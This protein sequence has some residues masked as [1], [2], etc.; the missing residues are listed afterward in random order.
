MTDSRRLRLQA[1]APRLVSLRWALGRLAS[2]LTL[3]H[4]GAHPDDEQSGL[5]ALL[6]HQ[7]GMRV[8]L[9]CST[10][11]EGG[12]NALGPERGGALGVIRSREMEEAARILDVDLLWLG[13]GPEDRVRDFGFSKSGED[14]LARWGRERILERLV[15][16]YRRFRPDLVLPTFLDVP[17]QHG[18]HRAMTWAAEE[19]VRLAADPEAFP[20]QALSGLKP[21][22]VAKFHLPGWSGSG[23]AS[24][25]A[26]DDEEPPPPATLILRA[27]GP[28]PATGLAHDRLGEV[29]RSLH[30]TQGMGTWRAPRLEWPLHLRGGA[31]GDAAESDLREGLPR[32]LADLGASPALAEADEAV[33]RA[34]AAF[35]H[36]APLIA[37][38]AAAKS[39]LRRAQAEASPAEQEAHGHRLTRKLLELDA[40]LT[41]AAGLRAEIELDPP[42]PVQGAGARLSFRLE[43]GLAEEIQVS[44]EVDPHLA[45]AEPEGDEAFLIRMRPQAPILN[46]FHPHWSPLGEGEPLAL[47]LKARIGGEEVSVLQTPERRFGASPARVARLEPEALLFRLNSPGSQ[48]LTISAAEGARVEIDRTHGVTAE[49]VEGGLILTHLADQP[50][51]LM[52]LGVKIDG[53]KAWSR[54]AFSYPHIGAAE[55]VAPLVLEALALKLELPETRVGHIGGGAD[56]VGFWLERMGLAPKILG[57]E[58]LAGDLSAYDTLVVGVFAYGLRPDLQA[59]RPR[60]RR[61]MEAGG[62]LL[63]LYHRP[64]DRWEASGLP[65][66]IGTPSLRWRV[67]DPAAPVEILRPEHPFFVGPNRIRPEDWEGWDKERGLYFASRWDEAYEPLLSLSD[68]GE[69]PLRGALLTARFGKGRHTHLALTLHHQ[70]EKLNA[71]AFRLFA[72]LLQPERNRP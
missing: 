29:S 6:R 28:E 37:A 56:R 31:L 9:A 11:G 50:E 25:G 32:R 23:A 70:M 72:N 60:L 71:G 58:D 8:I 44:V 48:R 24:G 34:F 5:V 45:A 10:R 47:R 21:W 14:T 7:M 55:H 12:Q 36:E 69:A 30:A 66:T 1:A 40:A 54:K 68:P 51:G 17:G 33:A 59:A 27:Q 65:L 46:D 15:R 26:Y 16:A 64:S 22:R 42:R 39:A 53:E 49:A 41:L 52:R 63:T 35:P 3:M 18:H 2:P 57:P 13:H 4:T 38:L 20:D 43:P 67:T 62:H 19:A 61:W